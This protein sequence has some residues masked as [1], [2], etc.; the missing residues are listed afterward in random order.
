MPPR[1]RFLKYLE[2]ADCT[3]K[4]LIRCDFRKFLD[5]LVCIWN[6]E[7]SDLISLFAIIIDT[8]YYEAVT[9]ANHQSYKDGLHNYTKGGMSKRILLNAKT[10]SI[11]PIQN[12]G[13]AKNEISHSKKRE[14]FLAHCYVAHDHRNRYGDSL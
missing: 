2:I 6:M 5:G 7:K 9:P 4:I 12:A 13:K 11:T 8:I 3:G 10:L 1:Q 14:T